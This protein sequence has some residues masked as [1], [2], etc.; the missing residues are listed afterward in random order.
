MAN[1]ATM[2]QTADAVYCRN[3][4]ALFRSDPR[5]AQRIDETPDDGTVVVEPSRAGPP[6]ASV[7]V[8]GRSLQLHSRFDPLA[9]ARQ[10]AE[11]VEVGESFCYFV[12]GFGLGYH[13]QA[14]RNR[15]KGDAFLIVA[16]PNLQVLRKAIESVDLADLLAHDRCIV[17]TSTDRSEIQTRLEPYNNLMM[18]GTQFV[19]HPASERLAGEFH[20]AMR[21]LIAEHMT[22]CR[23]CMVTL[24]TNS[25]ITNQNV[26]NNLPAFLATPPIDC[27][28]DRFAG[29][30][31]VVVSAG[32]SLRKNIDQLA[33]LRGKAIIIAVQTTYKL[34]LDRGIEP[35]FVTSLDYHE[36][37]RKF[38]EGISDFGRTHLVAEPKVSWHVVDAYRGRVSLLANDFATA[39]LGEKLGR[40]DGLK[41]GATVAHL[42]FYLAVYMG[43]DPVVLVGQDLGYTGHV[44]YS[45]GVAYH[46]LWR[47][48]LN[49]FCTM[50]M[51][52]W[53]RI[54]RHRKILMKVKDIDGHDIYTDEQL[55]TYLQQFEGDFATVPGRVI[56]ATEGGVR[57]AGTRV[58]SLAEVTERYCTR[59]IPQEAFAE[60]DRMTWRDLSKLPAGREQVVARIAEVDALEDTCREMLSVLRALT[61]L[62][63]NPVEF[64]RR[65]AEVDALRVKI[66]SHERAYRMV[67]SV[68]QHAELQRFTADRRLSLADL[69][70]PA[71]ARRQLERDIR[72]VEA[73]LEGA[74]ALKQILQTCRDRFDAALAEAGR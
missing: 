45:P 3:M 2:Q 25:R 49:R 71:R 14:L 58:M 38:F 41:A 74:E 43:C 42:A 60:L 46:D 21:K 5:L 12:S 51:K 63:N 18:I 7:K 40:R 39:V 10:L 70:G 28:R 35:D 31:A 69:D 32:P 1:I 6:T 52:E 34:L 37:S 64:N 67:S 26:A 33:S 29:Y 59:P 16:E 48:E 57:K 4:A 65:I 47:P 62:L 30:P 22:Y 20:A 54:V 55:F 44:Y 17:L 66:K 73:V 11:A 53:E 61:E 19:S 27:L 13:L 8:N 36:L 9:E 24:V 56:D 15:L 23:M 72:F 68:S 50:E